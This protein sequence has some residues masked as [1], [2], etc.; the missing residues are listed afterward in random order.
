MKAKL[1]EIFFFLILIHKLVCNVTFHAATW[2]GAT[3]TEH[4][5]AHGQLR[6]RA[7]AYPSLVLQ[8]HKRVVKN[9]KTPLCFSKTFHIFE[10]K[11]ITSKHREI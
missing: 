11:Y 6:A 10:N 3:S 2:A 4:K 5:M 8:Y 9:L 1:I 7:T